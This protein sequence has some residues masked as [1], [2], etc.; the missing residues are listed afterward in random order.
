MERTV[1]GLL[2]ELGRELRPFTA[3]AVRELP[4]RR[5]GVYALWLPDGGAAPECLY[6]G[7]A[8]ACLRQRLLQHLQGETNPE[9]R[10]ELRLFG[11]NLQFSAA[12]TQGRE[13]TLELE[14]ALIRQWQPRCNRNK[15]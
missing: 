12:Y 8:I 4:R 1:L 2:Y 14:T 15:L 6:V 5:R 10:R 9:L 11:P 7:V 3:G 13:A